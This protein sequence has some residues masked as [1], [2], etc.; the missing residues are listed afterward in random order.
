MSRPESIIAQVARNVLANG[1]PSHDDFLACAELAGQAQGHYELLYYANQIRVKHFTNTVRLC[2]IGAG[3]IGA[4]SEDCKWCA[5]SAAFS[6]GRTHAELAKPGDLTAAACSA[7]KNHASSFGIVNSGLKPAQSEFQAVLESAEHIQG[8][9]SP[10]M[11]VCAS[12]GTLTRDQAE[13]LIAAGVTRYNHNLETSERMYARMVTTHKYQD[14]LD[15][16]KTARKA[17]MSLCT[18]GIFGI[19]ETW[20][21]R[22]DMGLTL[23]DEIKPDVSPLNFLAPIPGTPLENAEPLGA[24]EIL[25]I[26]AIYRLMLPTADIKIAGGREINLRDM[27]SWIFYAGATSMLVGNYL[28]T[29]GRS[30]ED[31][32]AMINDLGLEIVDNSWHLRA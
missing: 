2:S 24:Q 3:K 25:N 12:L 14:R 19:G 26:I 16:L 29:A 5:Q 31:D 13:Q 8:N 6:P 22:I 1:S 15:T 20:G 28:T 30:A 23:R 17:G 21:D 4:C 32:L 10:E 7:E 9:V 18:G 27:Q 11:R